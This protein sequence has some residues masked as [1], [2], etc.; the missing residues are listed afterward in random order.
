MKVV[1]D[2]N[3]LIASFGKSSPYRNIFE[4]FLN[5]KYTLLLSNDELMEYM[6]II[7]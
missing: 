3:V 7:E 5:Y 6:E 1:I 4:S 2:T